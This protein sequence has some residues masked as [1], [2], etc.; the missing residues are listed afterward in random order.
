MGLALGGK[1]GNLNRNH[2]VSFLLGA[3]LPTF[4][5]FVLAS[6]RVGEQFSSISSWGNEPNLA[7]G[8]A[9]PGQE[10]E[11]RMN[12]TI[13][14]W[15]SNLVCVCLCVSSMGSFCFHFPPLIYA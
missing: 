4:L 3:A 12:P 11:V 15:T 1:E 7:S 9:A 6:D 10:Q 5:L 8:G 2:V 14:A 13:H